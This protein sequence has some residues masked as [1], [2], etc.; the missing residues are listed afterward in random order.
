M[1]IKNVKYYKKKLWLEL[2][3][4]KTKKVKKVL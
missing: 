4:T 3:N 1:L 2:Q